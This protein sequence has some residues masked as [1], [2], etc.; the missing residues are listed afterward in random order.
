MIHIHYLIACIN[1]LLKDFA[2]T[3][4][5]LLGDIARLL[6]DFKPGAKAKNL[7]IVCKV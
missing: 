7:G 5:D 4:S 6:N 1:L 2:T 3:P